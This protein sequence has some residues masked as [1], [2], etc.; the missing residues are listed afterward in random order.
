[1]A[2]A[3]EYATV[4]AKTQGLATVVEWRKQNAHC[5]SLTDVQLA[6][7]FPHYICRACAHVSSEAGALA[8]F[9]GFGPA[10]QHWC[11]QR[12]SHPLS[13]VHARPILQ[14]V[15]IMDH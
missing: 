2:P 10:Q 9:A 7:L 13:S 4:T 6:F 8:H 14:P 1:M 3:P 12:E 11:P 15:S 5:H